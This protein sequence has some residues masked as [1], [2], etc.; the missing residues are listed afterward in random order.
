MPIAL[1]I[2]ANGKEKPFDSRFIE[3]IIRYV[4]SSLSTPVFVNSVLFNNIRFWGSSQSYLLDICATH[5]Q[6]HR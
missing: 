5:E 4:I 1:P 3:Q 2:A 6:A